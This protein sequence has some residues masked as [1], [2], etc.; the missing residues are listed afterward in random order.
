[1]ST[2][3]GSTGTAAGSTGTAAG[4]TPLHAEHTELGAS[5]TDF[6]GWQM[7]VR[8]TSE[9]A[10]HHAVRRAAGLFDLSHMGEVEVTGPGAA[11]L[12][13]RALVGDLSGVAVGRARYSLLC[14][15]DGGIVDD[16]I[17]YRLAPERYLVVPNA[18]NA[19]AVVT[20]LAG[21][22]AGTGAVV[23]DVSASTALIAVQGPAAQAV[24]LDVADPAHAG[25]VAALRYYSAARALLAGREVLL[26]RT[27]YT[28]E[29]GFEVYLPADDGP[30]L[31][32]ALLAAGAPRGLLPAGLAARDTL[33]L[34]AGMPLY[35]HEL[36]RDVDPYAAGLGAVVA[37]GKAD[38]VGR[39]ALAAARDADPGAPGAGGRRVLVG[40]SGAGR[41][42]ARAGHLVHTPG[43][44]GAAVGVVTSGALSPTLGHPIALAHVAADHA[45][46]GTVV[47][48]DVRG[49]R[50][51]FDVVALPFYRRTR[52]TPV[53]LPVPT[54]A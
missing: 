50:Q 53:P 23:L 9:L 3:A 5:F 2:A 32:R 42:A 34:E 49:A 48:V 7:P 10:E 24:V 14:A 45:A 25:A 18:A 12:L 39:E 54:T 46:V 51:P 44:T 21:L 47:E 19:G 26:A 28:G 20:A 4:S 43:T 31:W 6:G 16:L 17:A 1:M 11:A 35:G 37:T 40:L 13:D 15:P 27:G 30:A 41:R 38:F 22:A 8:Y 33:R 29:D 36:T 52:A